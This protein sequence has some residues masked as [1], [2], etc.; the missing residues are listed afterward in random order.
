M[1]VGRSFFQDSFFWGSNLTSAL[2]DQSGLSPRCKRMTMLA[3]WR[4]AFQAGF[5]QGRFL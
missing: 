4:V 5:G 3:E 2:C 1:I